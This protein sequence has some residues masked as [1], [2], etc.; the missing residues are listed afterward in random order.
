MPIQTVW[1]NGL[2]QLIKTLHGKCCEKTAVIHFAH[3]NRLVE[4]RSK[5]CS[6]CLCS[7]FTFFQNATGFKCTSFCT[8]VSEHIGTHA[9]MM[10]SA[11]SDCLQ[12]NGAFNLLQVEAVSSVKYKT[13]TTHGL[14]LQLTAQQ[15]VFARVITPCLFL[16]LLLSVSWLSCQ[17]CCQSQW[18]SFIVSSV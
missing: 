6:H 7:L 16:W 13:S 18:W 1:K 4:S 15:P 11:D 17:R 12:Y 3:S 8:S 14:F 10:F 9:A 5:I 2:K